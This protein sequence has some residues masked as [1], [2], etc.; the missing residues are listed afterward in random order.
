MGT[1]ATNIRIC[2]NKQIA[3]T[4]HLKTPLKPLKKPHCYRKALPC[5]FM[6]IIE[7]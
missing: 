7:L 3:N 4:N 6:L 2:E 5:G 1:N